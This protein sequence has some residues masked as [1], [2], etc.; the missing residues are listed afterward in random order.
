MIICILGHSGAGTYAGAQVATNPKYAAGLYPAERGK[1]LMRVV[2][3][4]YAPGP[5]RLVARQS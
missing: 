4:A 1:P 2:R 5:D 3:A